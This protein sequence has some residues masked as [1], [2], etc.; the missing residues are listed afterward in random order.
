MS[1]SVQTT[2]YTVTSRIPTSPEAS[3]LGKFGDIP[4]GL[5][6]GVP[7]I[8]IP[9]YTIKVKDFELPISLSYNSSGIKVE[10]LAPNTGLGWALSA[11]GSISCSVN[12]KPDFFAGGIAAPTSGDDIAPQYLLSPEA[13]AYDYSAD[14]GGAAYRFAK[15]AADGTA[16][17]QPDLYYYNL[18]GGSSGK[19]YTDLQRQLHPIPF[20]AIKIIR[21]G[22][23]FY[24][25]DE[26]GV[27]Y[28]FGAG[29]SSIGTSNCSTA[30]TNATLLLTQI[31]LP[32]HNTI[33]LNYLPAISYSYHIQAS[34][35]RNVL[36]PGNYG[37]SIKDCYAD[38]SYV[39]VSSQRLS[40]IT[41]SLGDRVDF[42]YNTNRID[43]SGTQ[44]LDVINISNTQH[45]I[46]SYAFSYDYFTS[47]IGPNMDTKRLKLVSITRQ[48]GA[49]YAFN[50]NEAITIPNRM[51]YA[52]D[53]WGYY[54]G[55]VNNTTLY[56][57][58]YDYGF[59]SGADRE[60]DT[61]YS[62]TAML[63]QITYPTGGYTKFIYEQND[64]YYVGDEKTYTTQSYNAYGQDNQNIT[65]SFSIPVGTTVVSATAHF[66]DGS[67][68]SSGGGI[69]SD[70]ADRSTT[71]T[72]SGDN[73]FY[74]TFYNGLSPTGSLGVS[75]TP[76]NY[77]I[78]VNASS[79]ANGAY[80]TVDVTTS[81]S[82]AVA[83]NKFLGGLRIKNLITNAG[84][85]SPDEVKQFVYRQKAFPDRS[86]GNINFVPTYTT[87]FSNVWYD[88][89]MTTG[90]ETD[91]TV[92]G[93]PHYTN[94][95][96]QA[97]GS[98]YP[99]GSIK[100]GSVG[101]TFVT[102]LNGATGQN[103]KTESTFTFT[104]SY[105]GSQ[106]APSVPVNDNDWKNGLLTN[107]VHYRNQTGQF[108]PISKT[109]N[110]FSIQP[111]ST[112]WNSH[113]DPTTYQSNDYLR[114]RGLSIIYKKPEMMC[115]L[116]LYPAIF[117]VNDYRLVSEW[118]RQDSSRNVNYVYNSANQVDSTATSKLLTY[119]N[120]AHLLPN[121]STSK[122]SAGTIT[123][124]TTSYPQDFPQ[125]TSPAIDSLVARYRINT[126]LKTLI[127]RNGVTQTS[128]TQYRNWSNTI[129]EP[130]F[131]QSGYGTQPL[132]NR[133]QFYGYDDHGNPLSQSQVGGSRD[134]YVWSYSKK[135][136]ILEIKN[137]SYEDVQTAYGASALE[138]LSNL[139]SPSKVQI[140]A[141][142]AT[143]KT[144]LPASLISSYTYDPLVGMTSS[145]DAK[146]MTT[147]YEYDNFQRLM[148]IKD[149]DG[150]ILK[151]FDY[152]YQ[153]Q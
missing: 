46:N 117:L 18:P 113:Y 89:A 73:G 99:L 65:T 13:L 28:T 134:T 11:G 98:V 60:V 137:A 69:G 120:P 132:E 62:Q 121:V 139:A 68:T 54:N 79:T 93:N 51:S 7:N 29:E 100:G 141:L 6:T 15:R 38:S 80:C 96:K 52:Q 17:T 85:N 138:T 48:D 102:V 88:S 131:L 124:V 24:I 105:G 63:K 77:T 118:V 119:N 2:S 101:Y 103:G 144:Q 148:N 41:S 127:N 53:H 70:P 128:V 64:Y 49:R 19:F 81:Q 10:E 71:I 47:G 133:M 1:Q 129:L 136:P 140:D 126:S 75:L 61:A 40:S 14:G 16:D 86:S 57:V 151:H 12:G 32:D 114:G 30:P 87:S 21:N 106:S 146:G 95:W 50:Y 22:D 76:G 142:V 112:F 123:T 36:Q 74:Q 97:S 107:E 55:K 26:K 91:C 25:I 8:T 90:G 147:Y 94:Y 27:K 44:S 20:S 84:A 39:T 3:A 5:Y 109:Q 33:T 143:L 82:Q 145:T 67:G 58:E 153:N 104:P 92:Y 4:V 122:T 9:L 78:S 135:Y 125:G 149:K 59:M 42:I 23:S 108:Q 35:S 130:E 111:E 31:E 110:F 37:G 43:L 34:K 152:H 45:L 72:L 56:P 150:N 66:D 116:A 83:K 115:G